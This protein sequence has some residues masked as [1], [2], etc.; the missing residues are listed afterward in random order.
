MS[1]PAPQPARTAAYENLL[2]CVTRIASGPW[3][4]IQLRGAPLDASA[5]DGDDV[6]LLG[7][8]AAVNDLLE[9]AFGWVR[10]GECHLRI[11]TPTPAKTAL[12]LFSSDG[13]HRV[14]FDLWVELW[15]INRRSQCLRYE[16]AAPLGCDRTGALQRL[17]ADVEAVI[18]VHHLIS[19]RKDLT[20]AKVAARL[21][22]YIAA[23]Q[24]LGRTEL[25]RKLATIRDTQ[26]ISSAPEQ[27]INTL[28]QNMFRL[29]VVTPLRRRA[30]KVRAALRQAR[31]AGP[32]RPKI[33]SIMGCDGSGKTTL[34]HELV[35]TQPSLTGVLTGKHLYRKCWFYKLLVIFVRP[36]LF[37][38]RER[39]D[40]TF[41][42]VAYLRAC[43]GLR[44][45]LWR[46][47]RGVL[48]MDRSLADFLFV[49]RKT[50]RPRF[51]RSR[52][53]FDW[54]GRRIPVLHLVLPYD[55]VAARKQ[56]MTRAGHEIYDLSM[57]RHYSRLTPG[58][59]L[60]F[61]NQSDL[62]AATAAAG[63]IVGNLLNPPQ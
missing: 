44:W 39:F 14:E 63:H 17:P 2:T 25:A 3:R 13:R 15:Q 36:L 53:L 38:D 37:Q 21:A 11:Q 24:N 35:R 45:K 40:E 29:P 60:V 26:T 9:A 54:M 4:F 51:C 59:Y 52:W 1:N 43:V 61:N 34:A 27:L 16:A 32:R 57:F 22:N 50:E 23:C 58:D 46:Q 31:L 56:E 19:K 62:S 41:A 5:V 28:A 42:P 10:A 48:L 18:Y 47:R 7:T 12:T 49:D 30:L 33:V 6:D 8:R 55:V 20:S